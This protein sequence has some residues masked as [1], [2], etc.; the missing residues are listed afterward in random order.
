MK[1]MARK[2]TTTATDEQKD[3]WGI[4]RTWDRAHGEYLAGRAVMDAADAAGLE[5]ERKWGI[6]R[7]AS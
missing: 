6:G 2:K 3:R 5:M 7:C 4:T 1:G